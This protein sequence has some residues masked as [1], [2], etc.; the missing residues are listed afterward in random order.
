MGSERDG[1]DVVA[2]F[3]VNSDK[4][5]LRW[6]DIDSWSDLVNSNDGDYF[7]QVGANVEIHTTSLDTITLQNV[8]LSSLD[9]GDFLF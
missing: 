6:I 4:I 9:A 5:G 7:E 3:Q 1:N 2:D 8:N